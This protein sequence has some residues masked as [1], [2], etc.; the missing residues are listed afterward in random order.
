MTLTGRSPST[1][2]ARE[3]R[4][5]RWHCVSECAGELGGGD[6]TLVSLPGEDALEVSS[7]SPVLIVHQGATTLPRYLHS[8][9]PR[10]F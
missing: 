9:L 2:A 4:L 8:R 5:L 3:V 7:K 10:L 6:F 1:H